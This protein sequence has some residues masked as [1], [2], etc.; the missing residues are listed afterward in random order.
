MKESLYV[1]FLYNSCI[2]R[3]FL[4]SLV[5]PSLSKAVG[6]FLDTKYSRFLIGPF[7]RSNHITLDGIDIPT[8]GY[9]S[10]NEFFSR[11]RLQGI[12]RSNKA[13]M[14]SP[15]DGYLSCYQIDEDSIFRVKHTDYS[16]A[17]LLDNKELSDKYM[18]G[19]AMI[20]RLT[21]ADYHRYCYIDDGSVIERK[22]LPGVLHCVRPLAT[23][24]FPVYIQNAREYEVI[25]TENFGMIV[26]M[27]V[28]AMLVGKISNHPLRSKVS[29]GEEKGYFEY[30]GST[31][32]ILVEKDR[33][34]PDE[35]ISGHI[36]T[37][38]EVVVC[39]GDTVATSIGS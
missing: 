6:R 22:S 33:I 14:C 35:A 16:I 1:R 10:F 2:G 17:S 31:I 23:E 7:K 4:K 30:G 36:G 38:D 25:D 32:I 21:P 34:T 27:E 29:F 26:Q 11:K 13:C 18:G 9:S 37:G 5:K 24:Q 15:C 20:F 12:T 3:A 19:I 28:G 39:Q 8:N